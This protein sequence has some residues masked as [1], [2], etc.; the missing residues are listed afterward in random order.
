MTYGK[1]LGQYEKI[2]VET[3]GRMDLVLLCY[4]KAIQHLDK[5][6]ALCEEKKYNEKLVTFDKALG[7]IN[8]LSAALDMEKG[9]EIAKNLD[10]IYNYLMRRLLQGDVKRDLTAYD[11]AIRIL[12][13]LREAWESIA[14]ES[15]IDKTAGR[16][17]DP[18]RT[19]SAQIAA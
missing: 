15:Q 13:G 1:A 6:R 5:S 17:Y 11:E 19:T 18:A 9:G 7:I 16:S 8:E 4:E 3:A 10:A 14:S 2:S 12:S